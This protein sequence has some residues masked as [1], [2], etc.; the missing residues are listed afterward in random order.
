M[1]HNMLILSASGVLAFIIAYVIYLFRID[2]MSRS[3]ASFGGWWDCEGLPIWIVSFMFF[4]L[5]L[6]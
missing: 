5:W 3:I 6:S 4:S 1:M 2:G